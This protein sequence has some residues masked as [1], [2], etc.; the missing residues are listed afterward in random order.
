[1]KRSASVL[2]QWSKLGSCLCFN[3]YSSDGRSSYIEVT[4]PLRCN[5]NKTVSHIFPK[6]MWNVSCFKYEPTPIQSMFLPQVIFSL[7]APHV[8]TPS[9]SPLEKAVGSQLDMKCLAFCGTRSFVNELTSAL[10]WS[11][12]C[13]KG[14]QFTASY[15]VSV[16]SIVILQSFPLAPCFPKQLIPCSLS[17]HTVPYISHQSHALCPS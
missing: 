8:T 13:G 9:W 1:M 11:L 17:D 16:S 5:R 4:S 10:Q 2:K 14:L 7:L 6:D 12:S 15:R 3:C